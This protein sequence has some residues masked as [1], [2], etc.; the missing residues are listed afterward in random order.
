MDNQRQLIVFAA[1]VFKEPEQAVGRIQV[2]L[3]QGMPVEKIQGILSKYPERAGELRGKSG[4]L[5]AN[6]ERKEARSY[7]SNLVLA[8]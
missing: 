7:V 2:S 8:G 6:R 1:R 3:E 5:G 4:L